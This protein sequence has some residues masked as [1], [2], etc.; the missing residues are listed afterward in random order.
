MF[1]TKLFMRLSRDV[2]RPSAA[3]RSSPSSALANFSLS[4]SA[5]SSFATAAA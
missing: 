3:C 4:A 5:A 2:L 1:W